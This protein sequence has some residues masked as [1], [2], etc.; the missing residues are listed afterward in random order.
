MT[1]PNAKDEWRSTVRVAG[2]LLFLLMTGCAV[3]D[4]PPRG[5][6]APVAGPAP[7]EAPGVTAASE[8]SVAPP[9]AAPQPPVPDAL[10]AGPPKAPPKKPSDAPSVPP[11]ARPPGTKAPGASATPAAAAIPAPPVS[12]ASPQKK[13]A[14][15]PLD[16]KALE[17]RLRET[18]AIGMFTKIAL[19]NQ[20]DDLL[21]R[22]REHYASQVKTSIA[23]LRSSYDRLLLKLLAALQDEDPDLARAIA[24]SRE[25]IWDI[26]ADPARFATL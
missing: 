7:S 14:A 13:P 9:E 21:D 25:P 5:N 4:H 24:D 20:V 2:V 15:P 18:D 26:L 17:A 11:A 12:E 6:G 23:E 1:G 3:V 10:V 8:K 16:L 22:F 19:K